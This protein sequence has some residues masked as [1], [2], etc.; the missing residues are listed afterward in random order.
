MLTQV[1]T[2]R[3]ILDPN[4]F[5][6]SDPEIWEKAYV[7][8]MEEKYAKYHR[9]YKVPIPTIPWA[10]EGNPPLYIVPRVRGGPSYKSVPL[11][12]VESN[13]VFYALASKGFPMQEVSSFTLGPVI[14]ESLCLVNAAFSKVI[15]TFH[16]EGGIIDYKRKS[17]WRPRRKPERKI[18][19]DM[20]NRIHMKVDG[21]TVVVNDW[22]CENEDLWLDDWEKWRKSVAL[23]SRGDFHWSGKADRIGHR[24]HG[25]YLSFVDWK[26]QCY[27]QPSYDLLPDTKVFKTLLELREKK[28]PIALVHPMGFKHEAVTAITKA[29]VRMM[30]DSDTIMS[31]QPYVVAGKLLEVP[32]YLKNQLQS[33]F[34]VF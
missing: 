4:L 21:E 6:S 30:Y 9:K 8:T 24:H 5:N 26:K 32:V 12:G 15:S 19:F 27:I 31:C 2:S 29:Q 33:W 25:E 20:T 11:A 14:G 16:I 23:C 17:F 3:Q 18:E 34:F 28:I 10:G 13:Q 7:Y 1:S 22:L